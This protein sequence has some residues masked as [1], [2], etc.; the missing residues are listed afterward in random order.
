MFE[1]E[2]RMTSSAAFPLRSL[3]VTY[4]DIVGEPDPGEIRRSLPRKRPQQADP[5]SS[6][7][8]R[9][10]EIA[11]LVKAD[12][13]LR[14]TEVPFLPT[15]G[16]ENESIVVRVW[17]Q[18]MFFS[19]R[20]RSRKGL[21]PTETLTPYSYQI[22]RL[23]VSKLSKRLFGHRRDAILELIRDFDPDVLG[24]EI[25]SIRGDRP[26]LY[27]NHRRLGPAPL[28]IFGDALRRAVLLASTLSS[29]ESG[30]ILLIDE[31]ETGIHISVL[32]RVFDWLKRAAIELDVQIVAT[33]HSLEAVD[34][35]ALASSALPT[36]SWR[37]TSIRESKKP[38]S[39]ESMANYYFGFA[40]SAAWM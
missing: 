39:S 40:A 1:S 29:L 9:G 27:L 28:S 26:V 20:P 2:C 3:T 5:D 22:N 18:Q 31:I 35:I 23:Q 12:A 21:I 37:I 4:K 11:H 38:G 19:S 24:I 25:A 15:M 36:F 10:A 33:T 8:Q 6:H 34:A 16:P 17:E 7:P 14:S 32:Q 30:G 13:P